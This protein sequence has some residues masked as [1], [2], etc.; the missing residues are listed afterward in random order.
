MAKTT[1]RKR[2]TTRNNNPEGHNQYSNSWLD[3]ARERP[4]AA[5][6]AGVAAAAAGVFLWSKR[7]QIG[8][9]IS[10][11]SDQMSEW[12]D[13]Y[14]ADETAPETAE[15]EGFMAQSKRRSGRKSQSQIAEEAL[16][17]KETGQKNSVSM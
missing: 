4:F 13:A 17:L 3:A 16:S 14:M 5:T 1:A 10:Q 12:R 15:G 11:L 6:A 2:T 8:D 9:Q 7:A